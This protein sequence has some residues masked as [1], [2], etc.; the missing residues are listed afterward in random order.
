MKTPL[1]IGTSP[2][3]SPLGGRTSVHHPRGCQH[4]ELPNDLGWP[5]ARPCSQSCWLEGPLVPLRPQVHLPV[6]NQYSK[7][8]ENV[9]HPCT[10][11]ATGN[12]IQ[13]CRLTICTTYST[14][15]FPLRQRDPYARVHPEVSLSLSS[16]APPDVAKTTRAHSTPVVV[17]PKG[18]LPCRGNRNKCT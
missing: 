1:D 5:L 13:P 10:P 15:T 6:S 2:Q 4:N 9:R 18:C 11:R 17:V 12:P 16:A 8:L 7:A 3:A 14:T